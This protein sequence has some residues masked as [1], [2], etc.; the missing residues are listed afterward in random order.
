VNPQTLVHE[1][2]ARDR[3]LI[4]L[5]LALDESRSTPT[6]LLILDEP[7]AALSDHDAEAVLDASASVARAGVAVILV[8]HRLAEFFAYCQTMTVLKDGRVVCD[9]DIDALTPASLVDYMVGRTLGSDSR[10]STRKADDGLESMWRRAGRNWGS[11][12]GEAAPVLRVDGL[13][14]GRLHDAT[15]AVRAGEIV[16]F[17]GLPGSGIEEL[18]HF[19]TGVMRR[20]GGSISVDG[21]ELPVRASP[22]DALRAGIALIPGDRLSDGGVRQ[23]SLRENVLLPQPRRAWRFRQS[24]AVVGDVVAL[25]DILP[26]DPNAI[27]SSFSGGNQQ[28]VVVGKWLSLVPRVLVLVQPTA[29]VDSATRSTLYEVLRAAAGHGIA[30]LL[31][32]SELEEL[33]ALSDRVLFLSD[34]SVRGTAVSPEERTVPALELALQFQD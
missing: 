30:M 34:G 26:P 21:A 5:A 16:G 1:L 32:S 7:T 23:L 13:R 24:R 29:G 17:A 2:T 12:S 20:S 8:T 11:V 19:I 3:S 4:S 28:K 18:P 31:V 9:S 15:F 33:A 14:G 25:L 10:P 22:R 27:L 6:R